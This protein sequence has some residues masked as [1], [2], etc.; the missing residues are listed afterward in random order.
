VSRE[1]VE[2]FRRLTD[3][4]NAPDAETQLAPLLA[5]E[6]HIDNI[7]TAITDR[8]YWGVPGCLEWREDLLDAFAPGARYEMEALIAD[9][10]DVAV[11]RMAVVGTGARSAA[12]LRLRWIA[13]TWF[14]NGKTTRSAGYANRHDAL[15]AVGLI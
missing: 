9:T 2:L 12:P 3:A 13:V 1:N 6:Y 15:K 7:V 14:E 8:T 5:P 4:V 10:D 11:T